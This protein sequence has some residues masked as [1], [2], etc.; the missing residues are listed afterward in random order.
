MSGK[1]A[2]VIGIILVGLITYFFVSG[3]NKEM[4][5]I[6]IVPDEELLR[7]MLAEDLG[8]LSEWKLDDPL[9]FFVDYRLE[10][11][12]VRA[13]ELEM[14]NEVINNQKV[15]ENQR[16]QAEEQVL[17]LIDLMEKE[18]I[19]ENMIK[20][21]GYSDALLFSGKGI[22][23]VML[24]AESLSEGDFMRI[25]DTVAAACGIAREEVQVIQHK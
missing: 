10:R 21:L 13:Q 5:R 11:E 22:A 9:T 25:S 18:L 2:W 19:V 20:A 1:K 8:D 23:T 3:I 16:H 14:L 24:Y 12:R 15:G 17:G 4:S 6:E 7:P